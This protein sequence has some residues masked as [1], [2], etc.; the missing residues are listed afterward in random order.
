MLRIALLVRKLCIFGIKT[1]VPP[2]AL[3]RRQ[4][5]DE[6]RRCCKH[7]FHQL[8]PSEYRNRAPLNAFFSGL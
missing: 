8:V 6:V 7:L 4:T 2:F 1:M 3:L 5:N